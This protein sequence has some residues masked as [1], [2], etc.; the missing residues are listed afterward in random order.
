MMLTAL[1]RWM[2]FVCCLV[3]V[4]VSGCVSN[5]QTI[6]LGTEATKPPVAQSSQRMGVANPSKV[7][8]AGKD[9]EVVISVPDQL[10]AWDPLGFAKQE[11]ELTPV[12]SLGYEGLL[13]PLPDQTYGPALASTIQITR[14][15]GLPVVLL[16]LREGLKWPDGKPITTDDVRFTLETFA[17][18]DYYGIWRRKMTLIRGGSPYR[19]GNAAHISGIA[20]DP[21]KRTVRIELEQEDIT[22]LQVL[23]GPLLPK[24]QL[25]GVE[26][27]KLEEQSRKGGLIGAGPFKLT[28]MKPRGW[29]FAAND[30][31]YKEKPK[32][33]SLRVIPIPP[34]TLSQAI[35]EGTVHIGWASPQAGRIPDGVSRMHAQ[36][37]GY[38]FLGFNLLTPALQDQEI[39]RTLIQALPVDRMIKERFNGL[40]EAAQGPLPVR[41]FAY[42]KGS[43]P[44]YDLKKASRTL[45]QK[46]YSHKQ[47]LHL[48]LVY[49][50]DAVREQLVQGIREAWRSLPIK[51]KTTSFSAEEYAAYVFGASPYDLYVYGWRDGHDPAE[52]FKLWHSKQKTGERGYNASN[53]RSSEADKL[54]EQGVRFLP[55]TERKR[56]F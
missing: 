34:E 52:L 21:T 2:I 25:E 41:S 49:P 43:W 17:R 54:L 32:I 33:S 37:R 51:L 39:R 56:L 6:S 46:G 44:S 40:A 36:A 38:Q 31:Y 12:E 47:P 1:F 18:P 24:H 45:A 14:A 29:S 13:Q 55:Q 50:K 48:H 16:T 15:D 28:G 5:G 10:P 9:T 8:V 23:A 27:D 11:M 26:M 3:A 19:A 30:F 22:F 4:L 20:T 53:Y 7:V 42:A 35:Q